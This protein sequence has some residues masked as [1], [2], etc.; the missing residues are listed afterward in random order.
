MYEVFGRVL[1]VFAPLNW[2]SF[3]LRHQHSSCCQDSEDNRGFPHM[4]PAPHCGG[5]MFPHS[6]SAS[7]KV[8]QFVI[9]AAVACR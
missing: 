4:S 8:S 7:K 5:N 6:G 1:S 3:G 9:S 2:A